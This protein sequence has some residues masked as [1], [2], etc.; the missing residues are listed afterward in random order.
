[1]LIV[2]AVDEPFVPTV[3]VVIVSQPGDVEIDGISFF[4]DLLVYVNGLYYLA[5]FKES[6]SDALDH[7]ESSTAR[8]PRT[9]ALGYWMYFSSLADITTHTS[10]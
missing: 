2:P 7:F 3:G 9:V 6:I 4:N 5:F 1:M 8:R 10:Q